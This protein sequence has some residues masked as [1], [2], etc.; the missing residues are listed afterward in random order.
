MEKNLLEF[1]KANDRREVQR[2]LDEWFLVMKGFAPPDI[3]AAMRQSAMNM[4]SEFGSMVDFKPLLANYGEDSLPGIVRAFTELSLIE[5]FY[6]ELS[7]YII[8]Q[9]KM[10]RHRERS[11]I[12]N[13]ACRYIASHYRHNSLS[14]ELV[15]TELNISVPYFSKL[16]NEAMGISFT[17]Y[18]TDLR[19]RE[20]ERLM[21][22]TSM[23]VKDIG[24]QVG[25]YNSSYFITVFKKKNGASPNQY[26]K[27]NQVD[28]T[29][30]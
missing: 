22:T 4:E 26:R 27:M 30:N 28:S 6:L 1:I 21:L 10:N 3:R 29:A 20:A 7:G 5:A 9:L 12:I 25:L 23:N 2:I 11:S 8:E 17:Q 15:A 19:L 18:V 13:E 16:F 24:E 14:S